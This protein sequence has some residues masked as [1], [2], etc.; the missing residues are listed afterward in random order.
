MS[1]ISAQAECTR[2][3]LELEAALLSVDRVAVQKLLD[4][5]G[6]EIGLD[7]VEQLIVPALESIGRGREEGKVSLSQV[8]V[9]GRLCEE[10]VDALLEP[11]VRNPEG[12]PTVALTV[13]DDFHLLGLRIVY[14]AL[15]ASGRAPINYGRMALEPLV[16]RVRRD[17][18]GLLLVSTLMLPAALRVKELT[19]RLRAERLET[20]VAVGGAPF[21]FDEKLWREVG[22]DAVG[23]SAADAIQIVNR[24]GPEGS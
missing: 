17:G 8:Y 24:F 9:S 5:R 12:P 10:M 21:R 18:V 20:R 23:L 13:L 1:K 4:P 15:K 19:A 7:R 16:E 2:L 11:V 14:T 3:V 6:G 22:A